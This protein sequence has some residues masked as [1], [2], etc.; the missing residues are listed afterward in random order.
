M[1]LMLEFCLSALI[2]ILSIMT[3]YLQHLLTAA[4]ASQCRSEQ[5]WFLHSW[6]T[7]TR[8]S[9]GCLTLKS[10]YS[11]QWLGRD[12]AYQPNSVRWA[13]PPHCELGTFVSTE[14]SKN[15]KHE[16]NQIG[17][18]KNQCGRIFFR[19][20]VSSFDSSQKLKNMTQYVN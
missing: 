14:L 2:S 5:G 4:E 12:L 19:V 20:T 8:M 17:C 6:K 16:N 15:R 9:P 1:S 18:S 11:V 7:T 10:V 3:S 13:P